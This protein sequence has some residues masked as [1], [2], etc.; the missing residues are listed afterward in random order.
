R[1][2]GCSYLNGFRSA[3]V[4]DAVTVSSDG[5]PNADIKSQTAANSRH[6]CPLCTI[7]TGLK[8]TSFPLADGPVTPECL[9][10]IFQAQQSLEPTTPKSMRQHRSGM[11]QNKTGVM[12]Q[13]NREVA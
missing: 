5:P 4:D 3:V 9:A 12:P 6:T 7:I 13:R 8:I 11:S 1:Y 2:R 10:L